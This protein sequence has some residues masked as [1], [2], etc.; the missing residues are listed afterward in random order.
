[1]GKVERIT[2]K[3]IEN[4][5]GIKE[6]MSKQ[7]I[8]DLYEFFLAKDSTLTEE[9]FDNEVYDILE[10]Y[11][12]N[13]SMSLKELEESETEQIAGGKSG[14]IKK[15]LSASLCALMSTSGINVSASTA[16]V[17]PFSQ[18]AV[19]VWNNKKQDFINFGKKIKTWVAKNKKALIITGSVTAAVIAGII[20]TV[21]VYKNKKNVKQPKDNVN[22]P[23]KQT[24]GQPNNKSEQ[25]NAEQLKK[26]GK[27][28]ITPPAGQPKKD[29]KA[30]ATPPAGQPSKKPSTTTSAA[31]SKP[32]T[33]STEQ[34]K[35]DGKA[36]VTSSAGQPKKE[37][38]QP[39]KESST[40][41]SAA[42]SKPTATSTEQPKK[43][44]QP[45]K[46][47]PTVTPTVRER[48]QAARK[49]KE[50]AEKKRADEI[51]QQLSSK[52]KVCKNHTDAVK[53]KVERAEKLAETAKLKA[54]GTNGDDVAAKLDEINR[55]VEE[56]RNAAQTAQKALKEAEAA[57][58]LKSLEEAYER[59]KKANDLAG[60]AVGDIAAL[61][62]SPNPLGRSRSASVSGYR[63]DAKPDAKYELSTVKRLSKDAEDSTNPGTVESMRS[64]FSRPDNVAVSPETELTP[65]QQEQQKRATQEAR[66]RNC[67]G[68]IIV[69]TETY[70]DHEKNIGELFK[71]FKLARKG[72]LP[73]NEISVRLKKF[74]EEQMAIEKCLNNLDTAM[75]NLKTYKFE[76]PTLI[77]DIIDMNSIRYS[78]LIEEAEKM[79]ME[80]CK[81]DI[82]MNNA[83]EQLRKELEEQCNQRNQRN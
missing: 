27:S 65:E 2:E 11:S 20:I 18:K 41:T 12:K 81:S 58:D 35:K 69:I 40:T 78:K 21:V 31:K 22:V 25:Q 45:P 76:N 17:N 49:V 77:H 63:P 60:A 52:L 24:V 66:R 1:M 50:D 75:K 32:T 34:P 4:E 14:F 67:E 51:Q 7:S 23:I 80:E 8:E 33:A 13:M 19:S 39:P 70:K 46:K 55:I 73:P 28:S 82:D 54:D 48:I 72:N 15:S 62:N 64:K 71:Q 38:G 30:T 6:L 47:S 61:K 56:A 36:A 26:D 83:R 16:S 3:I 10:Y 44:G 53:K 9:E 42:K 29:E 5:Q 74:Q 57:K 37:T 59:I 68:E 79:F 43:D